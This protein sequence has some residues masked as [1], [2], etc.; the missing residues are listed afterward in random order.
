M[1]T[2]ADNASARAPRADVRPDI[3]PRR[4]ALVLAIL[5]GI[6]FTLRLVYVLQSRASPLFANPQMDALYH[7]DWA[8][9]L[10]RGEDFQ[11]GPFFRAPLYPWFLG[12]TFRLFGDG[13]LWPRVLQAL[14]GTVSVALVYWVAQRAFDRRTGLVASA[15]A[16]TY[17]VLVYFE[18][19]L[20]LPVL[21]VPA[22]LLAIGTSLALRTS[23]S[24]WLAL[25]CGGCWGA[26]ALVRPNGL[27]FVPFVAAWIFWC[28]RAHARRALSVCSLF[29]LGVCTPIAPITIYNRV[30]GH[31]TVLVSSQGGVNFWIGNNPRSDGVSAIVPGTRPD[32][33]GG[34]Y[35]SIRQAEAAVGRALKPSEV[36]R[37]YSAKAWKW[38][39]DEPSAALRHLAWKL[40]LFWTDF[41]IGNNQ[42]ERFFALRFGPVLRA[43][44]ITFGILAPLALIGI[45][46]A[47]RKS[48]ELFPLFGFVVAYTAS[49]VAFFV[50]ARF[51][52][53]V[54]PPLMI[55]AAFACVSA[56]DDARARRYKPLFAALASALVLC[57]LVAAV[58]DEID[59]SPAQGLWLLG[60]HEA[61]HGSQERAVEYYQ[62]SI[63]ANPRYPNAHH[64][65]GTALHELGRSE[66]ARVAI[67]AALALDPRSVLALRAL[68]YVELETGRPA[69]ARAA[70]ERM[71]ELA[72]HDSEANYLLAK[73]L[74]AEAEA[75]RTARGDEAAVRA[76]LE[77]ALPRFE[78]GFAA[79]TSDEIG[80]EGA[81]G[82]GT[83]LFHLGRFGEAADRFAA[84]LRARPAPDAAGWYWNAWRSYLEC[85]Q[86]AG[87]TV[88]LRTALARLA[89]QH[90]GAPEARAL[91]QAHGG[92]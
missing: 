54:L 36:S 37:Y 87:R 69:Q 14:I 92:R 56:Y 66:E 39:R 41:E 67:A 45:A 55:F 72:P 80:F 75:L 42:D 12:A 47:W 30:V 77:Q 52:V 60:V 27:M 5:L 33:W 63:R 6:A 62:E 51:R 22:Y 8:R 49:V 70:A 25:A 84:A 89:A 35:D 1:S 53:P 26:A 74:C 44:P 4:A 28:E 78:R 43:L 21:E 23:S 40:R 81:F 46:R 3:R 31:D 68:A 79:R 65:L 17:W 24:K 19:E 13:L 16:A 88:D 61:Q 9:A 91:Q 38:I 90:A 85:L 48:G 32:W 34:Y 76:L 64:D 86:R 10:A 71:T 7:V 2:V 29:A 73:A 50:C 20:L 59:E 18:G 83:V 11:P 58:P 82:A 57:V 15:F